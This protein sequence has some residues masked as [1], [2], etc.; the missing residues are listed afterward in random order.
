MHRYAH[1]G[2]LKLASKLSA[3]FP[4]PF[5]APRE[6]NAERR[7]TKT[8]N[9]ESSLSLKRAREDQTVLTIKTAK[10]YLPNVNADL[11]LITSLVL[12]VSHG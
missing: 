10:I 12:Y 11:F 8:Q 4:P 6:R 5:K 3:H 7:R 2:A 1:P 9:P